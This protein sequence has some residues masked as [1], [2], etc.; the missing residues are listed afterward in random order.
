M[1]LDS[2]WTDY[3]DKWQHL[4]GTEQGMWIQ[5]GKQR[6]GK[7]VLKCFLVIFAHQNLTNAQI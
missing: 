3:I 7:T 6:M 4:T 2:N 5:S 1:V